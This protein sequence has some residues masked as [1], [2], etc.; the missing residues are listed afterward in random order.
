MVGKADDDI[1][2]CRGHKLARAVDELI[3]INPMNYLN[4]HMYVGM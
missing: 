3:G 4:V 2:T 1:V